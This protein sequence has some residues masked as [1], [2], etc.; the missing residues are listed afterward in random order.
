MAAVIEAS[1]EFPRDPRLQLVGGTPDT[2]QRP[3]PEGVFDAGEHFLFTGEVK[4]GRDDVVWTLEVPENL[5]YDGLGIFVPGYSGIKGSSRGPR[6]SSADQGI[7]VATY[8]PARRGKSWYETVTEP[9]RLHAQ[10]IGAVSR[11]IANSTE[12]RRNAPNA[13]E[14]D[15]DKKLLLAHSM[16]GLGA[17]A[18]ALEDPDSVDAMIK[19]AACGYGH[20]TLRELAVDI[21]RGSHLG[22]WHEL[23][24]SLRE[25][26]IA[27]SLRNV[28][29]LVQYFSHLRAVIEGNSC[30]RQDSRESVAALRQRGI[31]V[32]YQGYQHDILV[33]AD[34]GVADHVDYHEI[35]G[36][37]GHLAPIRKADQVSGWIARV[38]RDR[39]VSTS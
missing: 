22:L 24:P 25:G 39:P 30:L 34:P 17:T 6:G 11:A 10:T 21:P 20:P 7:A 14:I 2:A 3:Q 4:V 27:L 29:D 5:A 15:N 31:Y 1:S 28:R 37:A 35:M 12:I 18:Y 19:L 23:I 32:A 26:D 13:K 9:Q 38:V 16:G 8:K 33:R 36:N